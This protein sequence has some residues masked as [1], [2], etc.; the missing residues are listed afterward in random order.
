MFK[1]EAGNTIVMVFGFT[2]LALGAM[3]I[4]ITPSM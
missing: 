4:T 1:E 3:T 2:R